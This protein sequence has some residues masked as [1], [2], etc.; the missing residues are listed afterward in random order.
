MK[1]NFEGPRDLR[2]ELELQRARQG[3]RGQV[4]R[5]Q[6]NY[7][8]PDHREEIFSP[9]MGRGVFRRQGVGVKGACVLSQIFK[10]KEQK[11][12]FFIA[13]IHNG[14]ALALSPSPPPSS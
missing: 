12:G 3:A 6:V 11:A 5:R 8:Y 9:F 13:P 7:S 4:P 1:D 10:K 14:L 2:R